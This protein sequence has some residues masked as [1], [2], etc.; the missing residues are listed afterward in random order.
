M[1]KYLTLT[2]PSPAPLGW[3]AVVRDSLSIACDSTG[4]V[5]VTDSNN[6]CIQVFTAGGKFLRMFGRY[7]EGR[8]ELNCPVGITVDTNDIVYVSEYV[9]GRVS[10][11]TCE[12]QFFTSFG[13]K[14][15]GPGEF[16]HPVRLSVDNFGVVYVC[17]YY[18]NRIQCF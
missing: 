1:Y 11:F 2:S 5:Y 7:G 12:G 14:G 6:H 18:N 4:N 17:D 10:V 9:N 16:I 8:G 15:K 13:R 3:K